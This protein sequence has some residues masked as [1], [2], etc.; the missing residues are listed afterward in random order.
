MSTMTTAEA[1]EQLSVSNEAVRKMLLSGRLTSAGRV[2]RI[3]LID[4]GSVHRYQQTPPRSGRIWSSQTAWAAL[5]ALSDMQVGW[6]SPSERWRLRKRLGTLTP[7]EIPA[8]ARRRA[9]VRR[10]HAGDTTLT[11]LKN[12]LSLTG[13]SRLSDPAVASRFG[14][15]TGDA[16]GTLDGYARVG[17]I[18]EHARKLGLNEDPAGNIIVRET[19]FTEGI[20][21]GK[22][23]LAAIAVDLYDAGSARER[24]AALIVLGGLLHDR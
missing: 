24:S 20:V 7:E 13:V 2:G 14:L 21:D 23:P 6:L 5:C 16:H 10:F 3:H 18:D 19:S 11:I 4:A 9:T 22:V 15:A 12:S 8:L 1:A 17:F